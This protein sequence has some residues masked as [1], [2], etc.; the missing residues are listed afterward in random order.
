MFEDIFDEMRRLQKDINRSF[1][2]FFTGD[3]IKLLPDS[4]GKGLALRNPLTDIEETDKEIIAKFDIPGVDK[5]DIQLNITENKIEVKVEKKHETKVEKK[6]YIKHERSYSGYFRSIPLPNSVI[7][8]KAKATY[9]E[10]VLEVTMP[11]SEKSKKSKID[12]D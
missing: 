9:K 5:K 4:L 12:I 7:S 10:G 1:S 11:K 6:G 3:D 8:D 2:E